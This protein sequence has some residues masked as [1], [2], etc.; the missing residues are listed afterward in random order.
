MLRPRSG[1]A[2][3]TT[4]WRV[5]DVVA[6]AIRIGTHNRVDVPLKSAEKQAPSMDLAGE[7]KRSGP[8]TIYRPLGWTRHA[9]SILRLSMP[10]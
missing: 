1:C 2:S 6:K 10:G 4:E 3:E 9:G 8:S 5:T 7:M